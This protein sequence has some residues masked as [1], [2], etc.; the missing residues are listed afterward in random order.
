MS[1][2]AT[3]LCYGGSSKVFSRD[4]VPLIDKAIKLTWT[5]RNDNGAVMHLMV[6]VKRGKIEIDNGVGEEGRRGVSDLI[7]RALRGLTWPPVVIPLPTKD[8]VFYGAAFEAVM[9]LHE[10]GVHEEAAEEVL[11]TRSRDLEKY[12]KSEGVAAECLSMWV[13]GLLRGAKSSSCSDARREA[14]TIEAKEVAA[15]AIPLFRGLRGGTCINPGTCKVRLA[16]DGGRRRQVQLTDVVPCPQILT[17]IALYFGMHGEPELSV[18]FARAE[19]ALAESLGK[20]GESLHSLMHGLHTLGKLKEA[21]QHMRAYLLREDSDSYFRTNCLHGLAR[22]LR[23]QGRLGEAL[24]KAEQATALAKT[25]PEAHLLRQQ[26][27]AKG[28]PITDHCLRVEASILERMGRLKEAM[29]KDKLTV[30][31]LYPGAVWRVALWCVVEGKL[32]AARDVLR[33]FVCGTPPEADDATNIEGPDMVVRAKELLCQVLDRLR[34]GGGGAGAEAEEVAL[35]AEVRQEEARRGEALTEVRAFVQRIFA[36]ARVAW[37]DDG[38][39]ARATA[40]GEEEEG[41]ALVLPPKQGRKKKKNKKGKRG[42][43]RGAAAATAQKEDQEEAKEP[44]GEEPAAVVGGE[45]AAAV[46]VAPPVGG[47]GPGDEGEGEEA[48]AKEDCP[49]CLHPLGA[50]GGEGEEGVLIMCG[51]E[52]HVTCLDTWVSTCVRKRLEVTCPSCRA[53]VSR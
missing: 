23:D 8:D 35:R 36:G 31:P 9:V 6:V 5:L 34:G 46:G 16:G 42:R 18:H 19:M 13:I 26:I 30:V 47:E 12:E 53:L 50:E 49:V 48:E 1:Q 20:R 4:H 29:A 32:E 40:E 17:N 21:E 10:L 11:R 37:G 51:H 28:L 3:D 2:A 41:E 7:L 22:V 44:G 52:Y 38:E 25:I 15:R 45:D 14:L 24:E 39:E 43:R 33:Q 27:E